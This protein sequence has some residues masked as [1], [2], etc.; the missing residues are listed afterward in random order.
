MPAPPPES[1]PAMIR[2]RAARLTA[3]A[4]VPL[5]GPKLSMCT[6]MSLRRQIPT[7]RSR[8]GLHRLANV[9]DQPLDERRVVALGHDPNQRL[10]ARFA[11]DQPPLSFEF[12][13]GGG[14]VLPDAVAFERLAAAVEA[15]VLE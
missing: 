5:V 15:D 8:G 6:P 1:E 13:L 11:D 4:F 14:N 12:G 3:A 7:K 9:I 10:G 2:I